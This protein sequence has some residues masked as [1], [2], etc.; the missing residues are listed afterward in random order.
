LERR[1][2]DL[3]LEI[4]LTGKDISSPRSRLVDLIVSVESFA[5]S[6]IQL[7]T[8]NVIFFAVILS[9][10][11]TAYESLS[12]IHSIFIVLILVFLFI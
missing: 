8:G 3:G 6:I 4:S 9:A 2:L 10:F 7:K 11:A 1:N 12:F 5:S